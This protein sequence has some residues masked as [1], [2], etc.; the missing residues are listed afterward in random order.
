[1]WDQGCLVWDV[2]HRMW[3]AHC[4]YV[5][6]VRC[7]PLLVAYVLLMPG[8]WVKNDVEGAEWSYH[9]SVSAAARY[10]GEQGVKLHDAQVSR[11]AKRN[12]ARNGWRFTTDL[13]TVA[14]RNATVA[15][16]HRTAPSIPSGLASANR[17]CGACDSE[18]G[19]H[20]KKCVSCGKQTH[21]LCGTIGGRLARRARA[22]HLFGP[23]PHR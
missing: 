23:V 19:G 6:H 12:G 8:V 7:F 22:G 13:N 14:P 2:G 3:D 1:M 18:F 5:Q 10:L 9:K 15:A 16:K 20:L 17:V 21:E 11:E 4:K